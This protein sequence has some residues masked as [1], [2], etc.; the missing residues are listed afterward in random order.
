MYSC[1]EC[2]VAGVDQVQGG[3]AT[4]ESDY[5]H[6]ARLRGLPWNT[7]HE[8]IAKFMSDVTLDEDAIWL[9]HNARYADNVIYTY[10]HKLYVRLV[11]AVAYS[12]IVLNSSTVLHMCYIITIQTLLVAVLST[13]ALP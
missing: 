5:T 11:K 8:D 2:A 10:T 13:I 9:L 1:N 4:S 12:Y 3:G 7:T 6:V